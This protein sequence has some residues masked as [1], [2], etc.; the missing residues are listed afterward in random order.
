MMIPIFF[1]YNKLIDAEN[2]GLSEEIMSYLPFLFLMIFYLI[3]R[4]QVIGAFASPI[5]SE[6]FLTRL[7]LIPYVIASN[8]LLVIFPFG[9][10]SFY[11]KYPGFYFG[12]KII[13]SY[14]FF[15]LLIL[16][17]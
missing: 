11:V 9:L 2:R 12:Y 14:I 17:T 10:H 6:N 15:L 8:F 5:A 16:A 1:L 3:L 7:Y 13:I 4:S